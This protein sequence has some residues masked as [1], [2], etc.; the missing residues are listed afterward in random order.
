[1][2]S[3]YLILTLTALL[4]VCI[5]GIA[6][7]SAQEKVK[8]EDYLAELQEWQQREAAAQ[9]RIAQLESEIDV[10]RA[11]LAELNQQIDPIMDDVWSELGTTEQGLQNYLS[12][13]RRLRSTIEGLLNLSSGDLYR[14]GDE[15]DGAGDRLSELSGR[16][17]AKH[18]DARSLIDEINSLLNRLRDALENASPPFEVYTVSNGDHLWK[19]SKMPSIYNDPFQWIRIY[20][21][22]RDMI[23]DPNLIFPGQDFK[24]FKDV[25]DNEHLVV[26]GEY[27]SKIAGLPQVYNDPFK[28]NQLYELNKS[29]IEGTSNDVNV[30]YPHM[31]FIIR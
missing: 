9:T 7:L 24:I 23:K 17:A 20:T 15:V 18:P 6:P 16:T 27:L 3:K 14:R 30:I 11:R 29:V 12:E 31:I 22:N 8:Y 21:K 2:K 26:R 13:L 28:W 25:L 5:V 4:A 19:I 1:M 10:L